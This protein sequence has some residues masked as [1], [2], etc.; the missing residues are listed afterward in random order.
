MKT[1]FIVDDNDT[2]LLAAK[3]ALDGAYR[4]FALPSAG[5]MF[6]LGEKITP[7]LIL[8]DVNMPEMDGYAAMEALKADERLAAVPVIFLTAKNDEA[9]EIRGFELGALDFVNKP[10]SAPIL[11][12]RIE[13]HLHTDKLIKESQKAVRDIHNATISVI[14]DLVESRDKVTGGHIERTQMYLELLVNELLRLGRFAEEISGW[15]L[16]VLLPSAQLHDVGKINVS[17]AILN[18]PGKLTEEEFELIKRHPEEG[19]RIVEKIMGKTK[20]DGFLRHAK[21]FA[22]HHHEKFDGTGYPRGLCGGD[23]PLEGRLMAVADVYD[24]LVTERPYKAAFPHETAVDI[25]RQGSGA[26]F[27]PL[28]VE[29]FLGVSEDFWVES[30]Q[31]RAPQ[32]VGQ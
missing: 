22:G 31:A 12:K 24:A 7:D 28:I 16:S 19:E 9:S 2:N 8:L 21:L 14:A 25:I 26:H 3:M 13:H 1:V 6:K 23:I 29:A 18:K 5:R 17:D 10:F 27:D 30:V 11:L 20:D 32:E 15:D 4:A